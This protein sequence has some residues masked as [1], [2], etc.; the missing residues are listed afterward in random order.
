MKPLSQRLLTIASLVPVGA[1]VCDIGCDHGYL[2]IYL[3]LNNIARSVI[4]ADLNESPLER[5]CKN[6]KK[7][8]CNNVELRLCNGLSGIKKSEVDTIIIAGIGGNVISDIINNCAW[9]KTDDLTFIM[10][11]TTSCEVLREFLCKNGFEI[12]SETVVYE[13]NKLYSIMVSKF[14]NHKNTFSEG[15][16]YI[17]KVTS[18]TDDG[19]KYIKKQQKRLKSAAD[20]TCNIPNKETE[21][22]KFLTAYNY[23][24]N[25]LAE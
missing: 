25:I 9:A 22:K 4:A 7:L 20:A 6:I 11:P 17:G 19:L 13:N 12:I 16:Y 18:D 2:S 21:H 8:G 14:T 1:R 10:Q 5:A 3:A 24:N 23:I 15:F